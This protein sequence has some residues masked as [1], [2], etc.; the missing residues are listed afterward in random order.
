[1]LPFFSHRQGVWPNQQGTEKRRRLGG[2]CCTRGR[3][4][5]MAASEKGREGL[6][7]ND[8]MGM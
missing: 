5:E 7:V 1:M 6:E 4:T 2:D 3:R 8:I